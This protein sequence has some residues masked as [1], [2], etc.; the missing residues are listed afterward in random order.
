MPS[1]VETN[2]KSFRLSDAWLLCYNMEK[3]IF[4][5]SSSH[6]GL[7]SYFSIPFVFF[8]FFNHCF[9]TKQMPLCTPVFEYRIK[10]SFI[11]AAVS[12]FS[13]HLSALMALRL[14]DILSRNSANICSITVIPSLLVITSSCGT[15]C[16]TGTSLQIARG[17]CHA[18][19]CALAPS[20]GYLLN[21]RRH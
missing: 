21:C 3:I 1:G 14:L 17:C 12:L 6:V 16:S 11:I 20:S 13:F 9:W 18:E 7:P 19:T 10:S 2:V 8:S 4:F 15:R 5:R